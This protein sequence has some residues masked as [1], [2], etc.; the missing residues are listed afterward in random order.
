MNVLYHPGNANVVADTL[1]RLS[2]DGSVIV[3]NGS[4]SS[5]V[6]KIEEKQDSNSILLQLKGAVYQQRVEVFSQGGDGVLRY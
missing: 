2:M 5:L 3:Q 4:E 1:R 6:A